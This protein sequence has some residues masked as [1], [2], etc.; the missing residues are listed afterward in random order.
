MSYYLSWKL[1]GAFVLPLSVYV[2]VKALLREQKTLPPGPPRLPLLGSVH[3]LPRHG[4]ERTF[5]EWGKRYGDVIFLKLLQQPTIVLNSIEAARDLLDKRSAK[6]SDRPWL[7]LLREML[8]LDSALVTIPYGDLHRTHRRWM[9]E[10]VGKKEQLRMYQDIQRRETKT[11]LRRLLDDPA[12]FTD[13]LHLYVAG[14]VLDVAYGRRI[15]SLNDEFVRVAEKGLAGMNEAMNNTALALVDFFPIL[16][17]L[18]AWFPGGSYKRCATAAR[19]DIEAW[20]NLGYGT[21]AS[22]MA[23]G[24]SPPS[25]FT[26][27]LEEFGGKPPPQ[28]MHEIKGL[29]LSLYFAGVETSRGTLL[30]FIL[31]MAQN[32]RVLRKVQEEVDRVVGP[33]RL[34]DLGDR[35]SLPYFNAVLEEVYRWNPLFPLAIP[36]RL[37]EGDEYRGHSIPLGSMVIANTWAITRD[38]RY[39]PEPEEFRPERFCGPE[40]GRG[41]IPLPSSF[42]F[43]YGRRICPGMAFADTSIWLAMG[44]I[45]ALFD[46]RGTVDK[47]GNEITPDPGFPPGLTSQPGPF[48]CRITP[49]SERA[50]ALITEME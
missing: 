2:L 11:L 13:H 8:G 9:Y 50:A 43:G 17:R 24:I 27:I 16:R 5:A 10:A 28:E 18:P 12:G 26:T 35:P 25:I 46:I 23:A 40:T 48:S 21:V 20:M 31:N 39:Y 33:E 7:L 44:S 38:E 32:A 3:K 34:P 19:E 15:A 45:I 42:V 29:G 4:Q 6:Y 41:D 36:H 14:I 47:A 1:L 49:R 37:M 30:T 22:A